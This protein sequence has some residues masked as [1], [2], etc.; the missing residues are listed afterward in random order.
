[1]NA[2]NTNKNSIL[3][4]FVIF[5]SC[6]PKPRTTT[7]KINGINWIGF[8]LVGRIEMPIQETPK[9]NAIFDIFDPTTAPIAIDSVPFSTDEIPTNISGAEVPRATIVSPIVNSL[10][11]SFFAIKDELSI[12][13]SAPHIKTDNEMINP[14]R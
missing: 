6:N 8:V 1:M 12:N 9:I 10:K 11:P 13:L 3:S 7:A 4:A 14:I 5:K 2:A